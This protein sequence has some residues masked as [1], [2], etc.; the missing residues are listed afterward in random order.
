MIRNKERFTHIGD[1]R[2]PCG[3]IYGEFEDKERPGVKFFGQFKEMVRETQP[4]DR[5]SP[6][7]KAEVAVE[8]MG[9]VLYIT[10]RIN[11]QVSNMND[12]YVFVDGREVMDQLK[13]LV[14]KG[15]LTPFWIEI[16]G[17]WMNIMYSRG[18]KRYMTQ[19]V[20]LEEP[21]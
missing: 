2:A 17:N 14:E 7:N 4:S 8:Y 20:A 10:H 19:I 12:D 9:M 13:A 11:D 6:R 21:A 15:K 16:R 5:I 18:K 3:L 1:W